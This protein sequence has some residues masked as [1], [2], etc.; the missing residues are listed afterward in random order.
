MIELIIS[1]LALILS[2]ISLRRTSKYKNFDIKLRYLYEL[3][4]VRSKANL[5]HIKIDQRI[6]MVNEAKHICEVMV[7]Q[8]SQLKSRY[9]LEGKDVPDEVLKVLDK[10]SKTIEEVLEIEKSNKE[11][12]NGVKSSE[13]NLEKLSSLTDNLRDKDFSDLHNLKTIIQQRLNEVEANLED[14]KGLYNEFKEFTLV[15]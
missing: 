5:V 3:Y 12:N 9:E 6:S 10:S 13:E 14:I 11:F 7:E 4:E 2:G 15:T 1:V 8:A